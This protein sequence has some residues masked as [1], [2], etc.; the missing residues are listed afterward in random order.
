MQKYI[1]EILKIGSYFSMHFVWLNF[2]ACFSI[3]SILYIIFV[4]IQAFVLL[5]KR[6]ENGVKMCFKIIDKGEKMKNSHN[7]YN[8]NTEVQLTHFSG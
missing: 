8:Q 3:K 1:G 5:W 2:Q 7:I 6:G 4:A